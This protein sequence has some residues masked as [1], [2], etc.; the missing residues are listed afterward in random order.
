MPF[1]CR[2]CSSDAYDAVTVRR[3]DGTVYQSTLLACHGCSTVFTDPVRFSNPTDPPPGQ[4]VC[5][6]R[7]ES[8]RTAARRERASRR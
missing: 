1:R 5:V 4:I 7:W 2:V 3:P 8:Q 6:P